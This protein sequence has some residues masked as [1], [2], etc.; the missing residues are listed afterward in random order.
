[1][2]GIDSEGAATHSRYFLTL[3]ALSS[4]Y[5]KLPRK[6]TIMNWSHWKILPL[7]LLLLGCKPTEPSR[8]PAVKAQRPRNVILLIGDG[9]GISHLTAGMV[10]QK[11]PLAIE[12]LPVTG[13]H[14]PHAYDDLITDSAAGATAFATGV[15]ARKGT[16]G[17]NPDGEPVKNIL[18]EAEAN[19]YATGLVTTATVVHPT[20]AAFLA[21]LPLRN[22][23]EAVAQQFLETEIDLFI[24]GGLKYFLPE[25]ASDEGVYQQ[26]LDKGY[27][28][29]S[30][31][32]GRLQNIPLDFSRKFGYF[33]AEG[34]PP[35]FSEGRD[36]LPLASQLA[37]RFLQRASRKGFFLMIEGAQI[38][39]ASHQNDQEYLIEEVLDFDRAVEEVM[40]F[41]TRDKETLV[42]VTADHE[43]GGYSIQP[44]STPDALIAGF[45]TEKHTGSLIPVMAYGPGAELFRGI[46]DNTAIY[47]K[48]KQALGWW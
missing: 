7:L 8:S 15:K 24:G 25:N 46:Y 16:L 48:M 9:L 20:P 29:S 11:S 12:Q 33:T 41:A 43:T 10:R 17:L 36:Y 40:R 4:F 18:E 35:K 32:E 14:K 21:H 6:S 26:L 47:H 30:Y 3:S 34:D 22:Q 27:N 42:I 23:Y 44:G 39:W 38:D 37:T 1:M 31:R 45:A 5:Q 19:G 2:Q 28:L 13:L